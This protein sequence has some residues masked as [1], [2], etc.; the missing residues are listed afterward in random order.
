MHFQLIKTTLRIQLIFI[1][2]FNST[3]TAAALAYRCRTSLKLFRAIKRQSVAMVTRSVRVF[4]LDNK[5]IKGHASLLY[6]LHS[7]ELTEQGKPRSE[8]PHRQFHP[9]IH[10]LLLNLYYSK[11][12]RQPPPPHKSSIDERR[13]IQ[14]ME[15]H[16]T[17]LI[18]IFF[19]SMPLRGYYSQKR[20]VN[21]LLLVGRLRCW[22]S[23]DWSQGRSIASSQNFLTRSSPE[24]SSTAAG[25]FV[26]MTRLQFP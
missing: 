6:G 1:R 7:Y 19:F 15:R 2:P 17:Q 11:C 26:S 5:Y 16:G 13:R 23:L 4:C 20:T 14:D 18:V 24:S 9:L 3:A 10:L 22:C 8:P 21:S 25:S 12:I